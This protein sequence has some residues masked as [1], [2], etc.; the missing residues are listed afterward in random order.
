MNNVVL[1][2]G[3]TAPQNGFGALPIQRISKEE[4]VS[5]LLK[6]YR[7]GM[8]FFDTAHLYSDSEEKVGTAFGDGTGLRGKVF[9]ATKS[10]AR[11]PDELKRDIEQSL[12]RLRTSYIDIFQL[13]QAS[14]CYVPGD[15]TGLYEVLQEFKAQGKIRHIGITA[16]QITVAEQAVASG[17][18]ETL[19]YPLSYLASEREIALVHTCAQNHVGFIAM[20][21]MAGGM[22]ANSRAAMAFMAQF[23]NV[24][25][26]WGIQREKE[27]DEWLSY[28][29]KTPVLDDAIQ[30]FIKEEQIELAGDFCRGCGYCM[31]CPVGIKINNCARTSLLLRRAPS[32]SWLS[33]EWQAEML[34]IES[35][36]H[37]NSCS[38]KCPY[39]LDTP[40]L[41][42]KNLADYKQVLAGKVKV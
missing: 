40:A 18:Y 38:S 25:P 35:C 10:M 17:L 29:D 34:K 3:I 9:I 5:L 19:Q 22:I 31:P 8:T 33:P 14:Q 20:K 23:N 1:C 42:Q 37:C 27:L 36:L 21:G 41:L 6:A 30:A 24:M 15:G 7:G 28:M 2:D 12:E 39:S 13:H 16:H 4:A 11:T 32:A 26:I